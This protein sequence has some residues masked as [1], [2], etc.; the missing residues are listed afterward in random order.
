MAI[1]SSK[2]LGI[3]PAPTIL[4]IPYELILVF[5]AFLLRGYRLLIRIYY[6]LL[7][8]LLERQVK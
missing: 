8:Q 6:S 3:A 5:C 7:P 1:A 2:S 4:Y